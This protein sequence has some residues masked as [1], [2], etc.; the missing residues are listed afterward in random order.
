MPN[1]FAK[2]EDL[3]QHVAAELAKIKSASDAALKK[4][5]LELGPVR[6]EYMSGT[7]IIDMLYF[8]HDPS[9]Q[10]YAV[11]KA[12][13]DKHGKEVMAAIDAELKA[14]KE[15]ATWSATQK[16]PTGANSLSRYTQYGTVL[17]HINFGVLPA[18]KK[19]M[20][21]TK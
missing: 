21:T 20:H 17:H 18:I 1:V 16:W 10:H 13:V 2:Q 14:L 12:F 9:D 4:H 19:L 5:A 6:N 15:L 7:S 3:E 8:E 11:V